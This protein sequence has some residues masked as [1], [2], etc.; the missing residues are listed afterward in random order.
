[1]KNKLKQF[2]V[3]AGM[4]QADVAKI[5]GVTQ[6]NYQRWESGAA[7]IPEA[8]LR[9]LAKAFNVSTEQILGRHP[10]IEARLYDDSAGDELDY[11]GEVAIHFL[12]GGDALLLSISEAEFSR[13]HDNLQSNAAFVTVQ[14][15]ANQTVAIRT[16]AIADLYFSSEAY[17]TY[18][19]EHGA[20]KRH[21]GVQIPD[22]RDWGIIEALAFDGV[23]LEDFHAE[24]IDRVRSMIMITDDEYGKLVT[25]GRIAPDQL[26]NERS[27]N[28][29]KTDLIFEAATDVVYQLSSGVRRR[30]YVDN[31]DDL[32]NA[33]Y[34]LIAF[35]GGHPS[36]DMIV[37]SAEG[38]HRIAFINKGALDYVVIPSHRYQDGAVEAGAADLDE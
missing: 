16:K 8:K 13:L 6:P 24:D 20:Y 28:Q 36:D 17:D 12:G 19:P 18:G 11:Y 3:A 38:R 9:K 29:E 14:S 26:E 27:K 4:T 32:Y 15:L 21:L 35:D 25:D 33:F 5:A 34:E 1:M 22:A 10:P 23:G 30:V 7:P 2:R 31:S 37:L